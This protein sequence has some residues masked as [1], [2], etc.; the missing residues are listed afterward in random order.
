MTMLITGMTSPA[1]GNPVKNQF[2]IYDQNKNVSYFKSYN[3]II[4]KRDHNGQIW[5]DS[6]TWNYSATTAKYRRK[7]L[8]EGIDDTRAKIKS[9]EYKLT[10]LNGF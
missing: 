4:V 10:D 5:L 1:S 6:R 2:V 3:S 7:F 8:Y 9:G